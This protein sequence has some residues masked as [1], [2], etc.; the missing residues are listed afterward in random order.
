[1]YAGSIA[2]SG[3]VVFDRKLRVGR[4]L[5]SLA[6]IGRWFFPNEVVEGLG[7]R[8]EVAYRGLRPQVLD[9]IID[10]HRVVGG[11]DQKSAAG[12]VNAR[13]LLI[14]S[15]RA[16]VAALQVALDPR[17]RKLDREATFASAIGLN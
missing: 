12:N 15:K 3:R 11:L 2:S 14:A 6:D 13:S 1:L 7:E 8:K 10:A 17:K 4:D 16:F 9:A 5:S